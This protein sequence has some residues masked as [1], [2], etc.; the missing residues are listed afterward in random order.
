[1]SISSP[2]AVSLIERF[3]ARRPLR[4]GSLIVTVFG[5]VVVP[6]GGEVW[7]GS[8]IE[9]LSTL[10]VSDRLVRTA[11][12]RL[13]K[14][15]TL[16]NHAVGRR[17]YYAL[18]DTGSGVFQAA[19][20]RIY[21]RA[22][23]SFDGRWSLALLHR[24][25]RAERAAVRKELRWAGYGQFGSEV[26]ARPG[27]DL[28]SART[29]LANL[30]VAAQVPL[31][32]CKDALDGAPLAEQADMAWDLRAIEVAYRDFLRVFE[33]VLLSLQA[34]SPRSDADSFW[35]R[36]LL[37]HEYRRALLR[38]PRLPEDMLPAPWSGTTAFEL[39]RDIYWR[40][41]REAERYVS[42]LFV[43]R[44]GSLP[45]VAATFAERFEGER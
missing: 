25:G 32:R 9:C 5:D 43:G 14:D 21:A 37:V 29:L 39:A 2:A 7:L 1:M 27:D 11:V 16:V 24:L 6:R 44:R 34:D 26:L 41:A 31:L 17:S 30:S 19:S 36:T 10:G 13:V 28:A 15:G 3:K 18:T 33:P 40:V 42:G 4:T 12:F 23:E 8:L 22:P 20:K 35:I 38:D 45:P